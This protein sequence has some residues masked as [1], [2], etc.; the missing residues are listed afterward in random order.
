MFRSV[1]RILMILLALT[2]AAP[3][4]PAFNGLVGIE[5]AQAQTVKKKR[6]RKTLFDVLFKRRKTKRKKRKRNPA[7]GRPG[8][9]LG[10]FGASNRRKRQAAAEQQKRRSRKKAPKVVV[11][12]SKDAG[13]ILVVGDFMAKSLAQGLERH[14]AA[15]SNVIVVDKTNPNTGLVRSG[16]GKLA[17]VLPGLVDEIKPKA[18]VVLVGMNDRQPMKLEAGSIAKLSEEWLKEYNKRVENLA[19]LLEGK[20]TPMVWVGL[21]PV[22]YDKSNTDYLAFN[23]IY[24]N[25]SETFG[26]SYVD[27]W[28]GFTNEEGKYV[29]SGPDVSGRIVKLRGSKGISML[30][31]GRAKLAFYVD[32]MLKKIGV[33]VDPQNL[34]YASLGT[35]NTNAAQRSAPNYDPI[36]TGKTVVISLSS[37]NSDGG[38]V[39]EGEKGFLDTE[40][41]KK[42]V[43]Y[44]L[45]ENGLAQLPRKGRIDAG[46][47]VPAEPAKANEANDKKKE[48]SAATN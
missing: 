13:K 9:G 26:V 43:S 45:V 17:D 19:G 36:K 38:A 18:V 16:K 23:E 25:K 2:I 5:Q 28:D 33:V 21:P 29:R 42:S 11:V 24:K 47:G 12:K 6:K 4:V 48:N 30:T 34:L 44:S 37:P 39:L 14:Y 27:V 40:D 46:W 41:R 1:A 32:R 20:D 15:Y 35:I 10:L 8:E 31:A 7:F 22:K 3:E